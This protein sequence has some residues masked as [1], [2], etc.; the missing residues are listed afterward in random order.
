MARL[1]KMIYEKTIKLPRSIEEA[2]A[3]H[4]NIENLPKL[5][6]PDTLVEVVLAP[7]SF[8]KDAIIK[9]KAQ[10]GVRMMNWTVQIVEF[11]PPYSFTDTALVSPFKSWK[12]THCFFEKEGEAFMK[13][14]V[15]FELPFGWFGKLFSQYVLNELE[16]MFSYRHKALIELLDEDSVV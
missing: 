16:T 11:N 1:S 13:D 9:L 15:E 8:A 12:H 10:K 4:T 7:D 14:I 5:S 6:P 3:F 2:F